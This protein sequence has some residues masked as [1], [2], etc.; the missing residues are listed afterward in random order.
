MIDSL[1]F[2]ESES[3]CVAC[4]LAGP[5][6]CVKGMLNCRTGS[7]TLQFGNCRDTSMWFWRHEKDVDYADE[8][9]P[10]SLPEASD[11]GS[12]V[13]CSRIEEQKTEEKIEDKIQEQN[14]KGKTEDKHG[15]T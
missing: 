14:A 13:R 2:P 7:C 12:E 5:L 9:E 10:E 1:H 11:E 4:L 6:A 15:P 8:P 3:A